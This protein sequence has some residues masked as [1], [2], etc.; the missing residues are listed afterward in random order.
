MKKMG[1]NISK[2]TEW[3]KS[4]MTLH[5]RKK[6]ISVILLLLH[7]FD[8]FR[9]LFQTSRHSWTAFFIKSLFYLGYY[10]VII[11]ILS[12]AKHSLNTPKLLH[13]ECFIYP[14]LIGVYEGVKYN[15]SSCTS[16]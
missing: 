16:V 4:S 1:K 6:F 13:I 14:L 3:F 5:L 8:D 9:N 2:Y 10:E 15:E 11:I 7:I 12:C